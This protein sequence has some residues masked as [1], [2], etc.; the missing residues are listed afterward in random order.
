MRAFACTCGQPL[1]FHNTLC[2][3]CG[4]EVAFDPRA[5]RLGAMAPADGDRWTM[6][7]DAGPS[8]A[9]FRFCEHRAQAAAC[10]WLVPAD[11][12]A[13]SCLACRTTRT[14]PDLS[15]PK[16][17]ARL[18]HIEQ[19]KR[20]VLFGLMTCGLPIQP[21]SVADGPGLAFDFL[22][23]LES[24][25]PVYTGHAAGLVTLNVAEADADYRELHRASLAEPYRTVIGHLRHEIGH[26]YWDVLVRDGDWLEP[27]RA[28]FGD[29]RADYV[30]ALAGHYAQGPAPD[31][32]DRCISSYAAAHPWE[33]WAE[34][35]AHYMH[36][37]ATLQTVSSFG[38]AT[39]GTPIRI[40]PFVRDDL[41]DPDDPAGA[42]F[43]G[44]INAWVVLTA[45]LNETSRSM[46]QPDI[47]PFVMNRAVVAKMH[48]VQLVIAAHTGTAIPVLP[49]GL[50]AD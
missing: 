11:E 7:G 22:E 37:R 23:P 18:A 40:T 39:A 12:P 20:R 47:Y 28:R 25:P 41:H 4:A 15:R 42:D 2:L 1:F 3:G 33:D 9:A 26:Y 21:R 16:N 29:E 14:I 45:V 49:R 44:W 36:L 17:A 31:W 6:A 48:F 8:A 13:G 34:T 32:A 30:A 35:W 19:A 27:F 43:L 10:N 46:G 50:A 5:M 38:L 24:G